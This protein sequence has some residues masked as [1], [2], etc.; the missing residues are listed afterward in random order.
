MPMEPRSKHGE[1]ASPV[2]DKKKKKKFRVSFSSSSLK[3]E[4]FRAPRNVRRI[5]AL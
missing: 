1:L 3:L 4:L 5:K 2:L